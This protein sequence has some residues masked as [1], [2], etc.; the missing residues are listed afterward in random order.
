M[1]APVLYGLYLQSVQKVQT[2]I[3]SLELSCLDRKGYNL[4]V[5]QLYENL[6]TSQDSNLHLNE[7]CRAGIGPTGA[8]QVFMIDHLTVAPFLK[9]MLNT[10]VSFPQT[11]PDPR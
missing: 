2:L 6:T 9:L 7:Y 10:L 8:S 1:L 11:T 4:S 3:I 5:L